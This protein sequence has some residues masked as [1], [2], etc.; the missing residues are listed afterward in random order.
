M[1]ANQL[2]YIIQCHFEVSSFL[3]ETR[4]KKPTG[5]IVWGRESEQRHSGWLAAGPPQAQSFNSEAVLIPCHC[6][7]LALCEPCLLPSLGGSLYAHGQDCPM[8][9]DCLPCAGRQPR[10]QEG[11]RGFL[12]QRLHCLRQRLCGHSRPPSSRLSF[13]PPIQ[14]PPHKPAPRLVLL[15]SLSTFS[16]PTLAPTFRCSGLLGVFRG[17]KE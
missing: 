5:G 3:R 13:L 14:R 12:W 16:P 2:S 17:G 15:I 4:V 9:P 7:L 8:A 6:L 11:G 1:A 10:Q